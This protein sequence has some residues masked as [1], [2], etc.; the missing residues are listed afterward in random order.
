MYS[1]RRVYWQGGRTGYLQFL[2]REGEG[3]V[4][5]TKRLT[6]NQSAFLVSKGITDLVNLRFLMEN[7]EVFRY[8]NIK[9]GEVLSIT[10]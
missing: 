10:K 7:K 1:S 4:K 6:Y 8:V 5:Q 9:T 3:I 2:F